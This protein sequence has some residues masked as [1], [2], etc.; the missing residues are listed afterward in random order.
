M[1]LREPALPER[2]MAGGLRNEAAPADQFRAAIKAAM[3]SGAPVRVTSD[4]GKPPAAPGPEAPLG[5]PNGYQAARTASQSGSIAGDI[6]QL[7]KQILATVLR[8]ILGT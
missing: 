4:P 7:A 3:Q 2:N 5:S 6:Y 1:T 8:R